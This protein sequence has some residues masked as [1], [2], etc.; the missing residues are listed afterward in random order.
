[1]ATSL[2]RRGCSRRASWRAGSRRTWRSGCWRRGS[3]RAAGRS[4]SSAAGARGLQAA[5]RGGGVAGAAD[6]GRELRQAFGGRDEGSREQEQAQGDEPRPDGGGETAPGRRDRRAAGRARATDAAEDERFGEA[7]HGDELPPESS[8]GRT[9]WRRSGRRRRGWR[10][11]SGNPYPRHAR[12]RGSNLSRARQVAGGLG[13]RRRHG[14]IVPCWSV[15]G[16]PAAVEKRSANV[17][18]TIAEIPTNNLVGVG[19][20][21]WSGT[22][23]ATGTVG[24]PRFERVFSSSADNA[25]K[26]PGCRH[27]GAGM[28]ASVYGIV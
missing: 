4:A 3:S 19:P 13:R 23:A 25:A 10:H 21:E 12:T 7:S 11:G 5:V 16:D 2:T 1:M 9:G 20:P 14:V 15:R 26:A 22:G 28:S 8:A 27:R 17:A 24:A 18:S 6:G